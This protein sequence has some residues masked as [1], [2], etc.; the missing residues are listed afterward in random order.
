MKNRIRT[1][2]RI[3]TAL[4][5]LAACLLVNMPSQAQTEAPWQPIEDETTLPTNAVLQQLFLPPLP[6]TGGN[7]NL[8][9]APAATFQAVPDDLGDPT[10][11]IPPDTYGAVGPNHVFA[12]HNTRVVI[13][14]RTGTA[15]NLY[16]TLNAWWSSLAPFTFLTDPRVIYDPFADRW[17]AVVLANP[18]TSSSALFLAASQTGNPTGSWWVARLNLGATN[19]VWMDYPCLGFNHKWIVIQGNI[20]QTNIVNGSYP[21]ARS[22]VYVLNR[23]NLYAGGLSGQIIPLSTNGGT[24]VPM[25]SYNTNDPNLYLVRHYSG[26]LTNAETGN[27]YGSLQ[28]LRLSGNLGSETITTLANMP[29]YDPWSFLPSTA[30]FAPQSNT[31]VRIMNN[32]ARMQS[33]VYRNGYL[34]CAQTVFLPYDG[35]THSAVQ[36]WQ[37]TT[38]GAMVQAG[39]INDDASVEDLRVP[40]LVGEQVQR[41]AHRLLHVLH[42]L[43]REQCLRLSLLQ[44]P[45]QHLPHAVHLPFRRRPILQDIRKR[46]EPLG[47]LQCYLD[48]P[49]ERHGLLDHSRS[50]R[51][52]RGRWTD[53][54]QWALGDLVGEIQRDRTGE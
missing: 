11:S 45:G 43:L 12:M 25:I 27:I 9:T 41:R 33:V 42:E 24:Q 34:W 30:N 4:P 36:W 40:Q 50:C 46:K 31:T 14:N 10:N 17:V 15:T 44:R 2:V 32:D 54:R 49:S 21:F 18:T 13:K 5:A 16:T 3:G 26:R 48:G 51:A 28:V 19:Q 35:P 37:I 47:R 8:T 22:D 52:P 53:R 7:T 39:R 20:Y 38:N 23:T 6:A 29:T 1:A